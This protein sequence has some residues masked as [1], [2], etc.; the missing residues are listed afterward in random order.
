[1]LAS[2]VMNSAAVRNFSAIKLMVSTDC[3]FNEH[4]RRHIHVFGFKSYTEPRKLSSTFLKLFVYIS[5]KGRSGPLPSIFLT[6]PEETWQQGAQNQYDFI[7]NIYISLTEI[8]K[9]HQRARNSTCLSM[10]CP[11]NNNPS[12][13]KQAKKNKM[14]KKF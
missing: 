7:L 6:A 12:I 4:T 14:S 2:N 13:K 8:Y 1:M 3:R 10:L 9:K 5:N 11:Y